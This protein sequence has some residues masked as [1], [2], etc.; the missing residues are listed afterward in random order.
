MF[1][2]LLTCLG[3]IEDP[4]QV[5]KTDHRLIDI[6]AITV[7]A[8]L[9]HAE[10]FEDIQL[11]GQMKEKWYANFWNF[12]MV[13]PLMIPFVACSCWLTRSTLKPAF[14]PPNSGE[15]RQIAV[16]GKAMRRSFDRKHGR[17]PLH[18]VSAF[19]TQNGVTLAQR[20]V[21]KNQAR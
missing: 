13:S 5:K 16:D 10:T 1:G 8:V 7:C 12:Q 15:I 9:T 17:A 21:P 6:L 11:Y 3:Q 18:V 19:A 4:R 2:E 14:W 20:V